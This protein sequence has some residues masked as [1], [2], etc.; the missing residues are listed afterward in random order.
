MAV[1]SLFAWPHICRILSLLEVAFSHF[2]MKFNISR[3]KME[4]TTPMWA[5]FPD[6]WH[7]WG[8]KNPLVGFTPILHAVHLWSEL[9][10]LWN[11]VKFG[12]GFIESFFLKSLTRSD[13]SSR[14]DLPLSFDSVTSTCCTCT[15]GPPLVFPTALPPACPFL[16]PAH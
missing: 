13:A 14:C 3:H 1:G 12:L 15:L 8:V 11:H 5:H 10:C 16:W 6:W 4:D 7:F 2:C 9:W